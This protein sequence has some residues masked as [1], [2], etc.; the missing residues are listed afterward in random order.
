MIVETGTAHGGSAWFLGD[1]CELVGNGRVIT[2]DI[3]A[4]ATPEHPRVTYIAGDSVAFSGCQARWYPDLR[5][6]N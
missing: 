6:R 4:D 3:D 1:M 2:V 5:G